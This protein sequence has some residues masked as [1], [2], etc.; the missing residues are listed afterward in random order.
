MIGFAVIAAIVVWFYTAWQKY[1]I[2]WARQ[3]IF[4]LRDAW[5]DATAFDAATRDLPGTRSVRRLCNQFIEMV[6]LLTWP[7]ALLIDTWTRLGHRATSNHPRP[8]EVLRAQIGDLPSADLKRLAKRTIECAAYY[9]FAQMLARSAIGLPI[10]LFLMLR[11]RYRARLICAE[12]S[13]LS[14][15]NL[16]RA[17]TRAA[18]GLISKELELATEA[19]RNPLFE[20]MIRRGLAA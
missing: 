12:H 20:E 13:H 10:G 6:H 7:G 17:K 19:S 11:V 9:V 5:F 8:N 1:A 2:A 16:D 18:R 14:V 3:G 15:P 4:E